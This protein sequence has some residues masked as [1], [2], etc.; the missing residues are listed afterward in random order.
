MLP[1]LEGYDWQAAFEYAGEATYGHGSGSVYLA[2]P[3]TEANAE[4]PGFTRED[5]K[6][7]IGISEGEGDGPDWLL[8]CQLKD[9]RYAFLAAGC[10]YSGWD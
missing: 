10:D 1:E 5:V 4:Q 9:K 3:P 7:I 2:V 6:K 8:L